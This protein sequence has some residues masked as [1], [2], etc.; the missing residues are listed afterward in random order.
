MV[1][2]L[3]STEQVLERLTRLPTLPVL[4]RELMS[5][6][7][8][9]NVSI[10]KLAHNLSRDPALS[11]TML[12]LANSSFYGMSGRIASLHHAVIVLG[13]QTLEAMVVAAGMARQFTKLGGL[14]GDARRF[15][16]HS[17]ASAICAR[18]MSAQLMLDTETA[19]AAGLLHDIG[20]LVLASLFVAEYEQV[21]ARKNKFEIPLLEAERTLLGLDHAAVGAA[22]AHRWNLPQTLQHAIGHHH[23][24]GR[25][26]EQPISEV[27]YGANLLT[28]NPDS[29]AVQT[30]YEIDTAQPIWLRLG[31]DVGQ[32][33]LCVD[34]AAEGARE[35]ATLLF[36]GT[37]SGTVGP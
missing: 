6:F 21:V 10:N 31:L 26:M 24:P 8:S 16:R 11:A 5:E 23:E 1:V 14:S 32:L 36:E 7:R 4:I 15:W 13:T 34:D 30:A 2:K 25:A 3:F 27:I 18:N 35:I 12:R 9:K 29:P 37:G 22:L 28:Q 20:R 33:Q 17:F 19:F